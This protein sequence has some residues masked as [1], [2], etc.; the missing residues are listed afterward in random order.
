MGLVAGLL[1]GTGPKLPGELAHNRTDTGGV[2]RG[3]AEIAGEL[4]VPGIVNV[5]VE[6]VEAATILHNRVKHT[7]SLTLLQVG[8]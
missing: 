7:K 8:I 4:A 5:Q 2:S 6:R 1:T 3:V